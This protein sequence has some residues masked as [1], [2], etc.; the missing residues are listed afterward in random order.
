METAKE[1]TTD[2]RILYE[3]S[4]CLVLNKRCGEDSEKLA[5]KGLFPVHRLDQPVSGCQL[6]A[7]NRDAAA[8]LNRLFAL[9]DCSSKD[10]NQI[11]KTYWAI[12]EK[13][14]LLSGLQTNSEG[15]WIELSHFVSFDPK[16]N[17]SSAHAAES[18]GSKNALLR[19]RVAGS[20]ERYD[21]LEIALITGRHHQIRAQL[22]A[23]GLHVKGDLKYGS[24]RSEK[25]GGI[26]L[27]ARSLSFPNPDSRNKLLK[28]EAPPPEPD[29]LWTAFATCTF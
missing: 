18:P 20:G 24:K 3:N 16:Q 12:V 9:Q 8:Y 11:I 4:S 5:V 21:F 28:V 26:R 14:K 13:R 2:N 22:A 6:L 1:K 19:F 10:L 17:K 25:N 27:H 23:V 29:A 15:G 7:K